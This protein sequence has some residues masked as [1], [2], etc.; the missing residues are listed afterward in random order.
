MDYIRKAFR[1][2]ARVQL[3]YSGEPLRITPVHRRP[4]YQG[5][6]AAQ[7]EFEVCGVF[8][9]PPKLLFDRTSEAAQSKYGFFPGL[10]TSA[11]HF[12]IIDADIP[13]GTYIGQ[14]FQIK[15]L[16][17]PGIPSYAVSD[18]IRDGCD[19]WTCYQVKMLGRRELDERPGEMAK[20]L[21]DQ[22]ANSREDDI[23]R[24]DERVKEQIAEMDANAPPPAAP[25]VSFNPS[26]P[27]I[28][29]SPRR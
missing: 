7:F 25:R 2:G 4:N 17:E 19:V 21:S 23:R 1:D 18:I 29:K 12:L 26:G 16:S 5:V 15:R 28:A 24:S 13:Q 3:R 9:D 14:Q 11:P 22:L 10:R 8:V 27:Q 6:P 20:R